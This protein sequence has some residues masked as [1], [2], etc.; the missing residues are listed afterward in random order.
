[1]P[2]PLVLSGGPY[3]GRVVE[4]GVATFEEIIVS[5]DP[6]TGEDVETVN[7]DSLPVSKA[8]GKLV[9]DGCK[10]RATDGVFLGDA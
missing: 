6:E 7:S 10:Y 4:D 9:V 2:D 3:G 1:M 5:N 8:G